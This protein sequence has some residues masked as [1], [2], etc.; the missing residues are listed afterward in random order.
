MDTLQSS[1]SYTHRAEEEFDCKNSSRPPEGFIAPFVHRGG[2]L[3]KF[4]QKFVFRHL[5]SRERVS[6][7][8]S[9]HPKL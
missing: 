2:V 1:A 5:R 9:P 4:S 3:R 8:V 6:E 7:S